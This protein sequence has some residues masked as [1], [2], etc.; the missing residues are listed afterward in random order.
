MT[1]F[2]EIQ[3][4]HERVKHI[5]GHTATRVENYK[6]LSYNNKKCCVVSTTQTLEMIPESMLLTLAVRRVPK[7]GT[8]V[9]VY[10]LLG[11]QPTQD[12]HL[13]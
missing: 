1:N 6:C 11:N 13:P 4:G 10:T 5:L 12:A 2:Y 8:F 3:P 9:F 7:K